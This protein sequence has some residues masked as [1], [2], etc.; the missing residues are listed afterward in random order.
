[1]IQFLYL[2]LSLRES[3]FTSLGVITPSLR[4]AA[5]EW[6]TDIIDFC[7]NHDSKNT[8]NPHYYYRFQMNLKFIMLN[9][10]FF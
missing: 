1:M 3:Y 10:I 8:L 4:T 2:F 5:I 9:N 6:E 7:Y